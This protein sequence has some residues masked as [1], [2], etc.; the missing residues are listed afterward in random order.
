MF[1]FSLSCIAQVIFKKFSRIASSF[2]AK[3]RLSHLKLYTDTTDSKNRILRKKKYGSNVTVDIRVPLFFLFCSFCRKKKKENNRPRKKKHNHNELMA[4]YHRRRIDTREWR[5]SSNPTPDFEKFELRGKNRMLNTSEK[6]LGEHCRRTCP[7]CCCPC[8]NVIFSSF[9]YA[10]FYPDL[11]KKLFFL[12]TF[13][14]L[15]DHIIIPKLLY[16]F[17]VESFAP[18][19]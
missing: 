4:H 7:A 10:S 9:F 8:S 17:W 11:K 15:L 19:S 3:Y 5:Q 18:S 13:D 12:V 6:R 1:F 2:L 14:A 16:F